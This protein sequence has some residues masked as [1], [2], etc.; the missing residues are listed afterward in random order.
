[1]TLPLRNQRIVI[2]R[3]PEQAA[4]LA[5]PLA[6][7]GAT[8]IYFPAITFAPLDALELDEQLTRLNQYDWLIF[9]SGNAVR[10][11][12]QRLDRGNWRLTERLKVAAVGSATVKKLVERGIAVDFLP[13]QFTGEQLA[14]G[15]GDIAN[16]KILHPHP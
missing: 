5:I 3:S 1:M 12:L 16:K 11:F 8:P 7:L 13:E 14:L 10:F 2:T 9:T 15:L 4:E 6:K